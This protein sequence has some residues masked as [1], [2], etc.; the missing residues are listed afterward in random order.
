MER[1]VAGR[2][3]RLLDVRPRLVQELENVVVVDGVKDLPAGTPR[4]Y[5]PH[6]AK[7]PEL[8]R[9]SGFT[10]PD[11]RRDVADAELPGGKCV[12]NPH[13][14]RIAQRAEGLRERLH[15]A[16][17]DEACPS[18]VSVRKTLMSAVARVVRE[19]IAVS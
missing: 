9:G 3:L 2:E 8:V 5:E 14:G 6:A 10:D 19:R 13:S 12:Q 4:A 16:G 11:E 18:G 15:R 1:R 7:E 17:P